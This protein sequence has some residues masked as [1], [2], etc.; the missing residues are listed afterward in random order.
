MIELREKDIETLR[1]LNSA[2]LEKTFAPATDVDWTAQTHDDELLSLYDMWSLFSK[3]KYEKGI[4]D[5]QKADFAFYQQLNLM[6]FTANFESQGLIFLHALHSLS[7]DLDFREYLSHFVKEETYH[8]ALFDRAVRTLEA[9]RPALTPLPRKPVERALAIIFFMLK[10]APFKRFRVALTFLV[11]HFA[12]ELSLVAH[13]RNRQAID[14]KESLIPQVWA[15][16]AIDEGRHVRFDR[17]VMERFSLSPLLDKVARLIAVPLCVF[18]SLMLHKNEVWAARQLGIKVRLWNIPKLLKRARA[19][20][21][22]DVKFMLAKMLNPKK[23]NDMSDSENHVISNE[24]LKGT[25]AYI[26]GFKGR[27]QKHHCL[28]YGI[29]RV[30]VE[31][32]ASKRKAYSKKTRPITLLPIYIKAV[33]TAVK[34]HPT[35]NSILFKKWLFGYRIVRFENVDVN[36]PITREL[37][38]EAFTFIATVRKADTKSLAQIQ[39]ELNVHFKTPAHELASIQRIKKFQKFPAFVARFFHFM[40]THSHK[41]YVKQAGTCGLTTMSGSWGEHFLPIGPTSCIFSIGGIKPEPT[42][43]EGEIVARRLAH[44]CLAVD[45]FTVSGPDGAGLGHAFKEAIE[46]GELFED[47][48]T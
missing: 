12:E 14:R 33:A 27:A 37:D 23:V 20:F 47:E 1:A 41:F 21:K 29:F 24:T 39:D 3:S 10:F 45:Q 30:D 16:H 46:S 7:D 25:Q 26:H 19:P 17:L 15:I 28:G 35:A 4:S 13:K 9:Q 40:M 8:Y 31:E 2:S 36:L 11:F 32:L 44:V 22:R 5:K 43:V 38:G 18:A 42:I 34:Q 6:L 48:R